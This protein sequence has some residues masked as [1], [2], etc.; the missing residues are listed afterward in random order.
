MVVI[1]LTIVSFYFFIRCAYLNISEPNCY[2]YFFFFFKV[3]FALMPTGDPSN[4][5][6]FISF[7]RRCEMQEFGFA[8][9]RTDILI[10]QVASFIW[11]RFL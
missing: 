11:H 2:Y 3:P 1:V 5:G 7:L 6:D 10:D 9:D 8:L 4:V